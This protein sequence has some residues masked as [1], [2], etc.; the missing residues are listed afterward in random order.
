MLLGSLTYQA[1]S[2]TVSNQFSE[3]TWINMQQWNYQQ[4]GTHA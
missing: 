3:T 4:I 1:Y 2:Y